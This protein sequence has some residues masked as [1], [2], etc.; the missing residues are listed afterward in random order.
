MGLFGANGYG[1]DLGKSISSDALEKDR[2]KPA[3][4][5]NVRS[6]IVLEDEKTKFGT[7]VDGQRVAS[8]AQIVLRNDEHTFKLGKTPHT[9]RIK[10][11]PV[12]L[13]VSFSSK[14]IKA[15][16]DPLAAL[17][18]RLEDTD[19]KVANNYVI[20]E[21]THVV[22]GKR[23][24]AK[25]LQ[26][27]INGK[28]I[29]TDSFIDALIY[30]TTP[31][32]LDHDESL[33]PLEEDF[34]RNWPDAMQH[35]PPRGNEPRER[36]VGKF[37]P[38]PGRANVFEGY[39]VVFCDKAQF[40]SLQAPITNGGGKA[41]YF[42][43]NSRQTTTDDLVGFVKSVAGE[44]GLGELEDGSEGKGVVVVK[45]R[46]SKDDFDWAAQL[47]QDASLALDLRFIEQNEFMDAILMNNASVLRRPLEVAEDGEEPDSISHPTT[48]YGTAPAPGE[49]QS[50]PP[51]PEQPPPPPR[52]QRGLIKSRFK[53]FSSD[54]EDEKSSLS[55]IPHQDD[56]GTSQLNTQPAP[57]STDPPPPPPTAHKRPAPIDDDNF[58][59]ELLPAS[60]AMKR[61]RLEARE[62]AHR[63]GEESPPP[64]NNNINSTSPPSAATKTKTKETPLD[65]KASLRERRAAADQARTLD[66][67]AL[68]QDIADVNVE[69]LRNLAV[70]EEFDV[71]PH[72]SLRSHRTQNGHG[73]NNSSNDER[74]N[75]AWNG[76]KNF[77]KFRPQGTGN[78]AGA[79]RR[80]GAQGVIVPLEEVKKKDF[81]IGEEY[82]LEG[83][84]ESLKRKRKER[85]SQS[86]SQILENESESL[87]LGAST[88]GR[89]GGRG[90]GKNNIPK[91]LV[92]ED[93]E[94][95][96]DVVDI[97]APRRTRGMETQTQ[98]S[99]AGRTSHGMGKQQQQQQQKSSLAAKQD[100]SESE[101]DELKFRFGKRRR[102]QQ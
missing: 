52:R 96:P 66:E 3:S 91:E 22:Q 10:W 23:N 76:R 51:Q 20:G 77:K 57:S 54:D 44:K 13:S 27:L 30:A 9:F 49:S 62:E 8:G 70:V 31:S 89:D 42:Q 79:A 58:V 34:D 101:E 56:C 11:W 95:M 63:R 82:W 35:V 97:E 19:I 25:G 12:V 61:R 39:T 47:G 60:A 102:M 28:Y 83:G 68:R 73:D 53:G 17:R 67:E 75:P 87:S 40:E 46:G 29:V 21:T 94:E 41:L 38:D 74:W 90:K 43:L 45:F 98:K 7:E 78:G 16:K 99:S 33:S 88:S 26:A 93:D 6:E 100:E 71:L 5:L 32:D 37:T 81:G 2:L 64:T 15:G 80:G 86:Q 14:E 72:R 84:K 36:P 55:S 24:T 85:E 48:Q 65:I 1:Y 69:A 59:D 50:E 18:V 4:S 92:V